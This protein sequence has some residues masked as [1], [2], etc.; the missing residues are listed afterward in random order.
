MLLDVGCLV[1]QNCFAGLDCKLLKHEDPERTQI[2][3]ALDPVYK[4]Y[5]SD[6]MAAD[7]CAKLLDFL[8]K[9]ANHPAAARGVC[10]CAN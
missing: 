5:R 3:V 8:R 6:G 9:G 10:M 2:R 4:K 7:N 1:V